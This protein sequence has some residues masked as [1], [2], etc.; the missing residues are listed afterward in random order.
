MTDGV[1]RDRT[2]PAT[3]SRLEEHVRIRPVFAALD[4]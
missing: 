4:R 3:W 2:D 1:R